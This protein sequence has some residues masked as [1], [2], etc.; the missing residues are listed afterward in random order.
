MLTEPHLAWGE[1]FGILAL[2]ALASFGAVSLA[3]LFW[4]GLT[5]LVV[6]G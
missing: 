3:V 4:I 2:A 6:L 5:N 1:L